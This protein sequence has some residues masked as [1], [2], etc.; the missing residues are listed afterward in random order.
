MIY[1][2]T[3]FGKHEYEY[4]NKKFSIEIKSLNNK[5]TDIFLRLPSI[6]RDKE[7]EV[8]KAIMSKLSRGKIECYITCDVLAGDSPATIDQNVALSYVEQIRPILSKLDNQDITE[9]SLQAIFRLPEVIKNKDISLENDEW[10]S[11]QEGLS[12]AL[13]KISEYRKDEG[14]ALAA[15]ISSNIRA[16]DKLRTRLQNHDTERVEKVRQKLTDMLKRL[17]IS[18]GYNEERLEQE[19]IFYIEKYDIN[20]ENIRLEQHCKY[21]LD[22]MNETPCGKKLGF[23]AQ[24]IGREINT[25]GSKANSQDITRLTVEM[26]DHLERIKEQVLNI[27]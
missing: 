19:L 11:F 5:N 18:D 23:I 17:N 12:S 7:M 26:K 16:I 3:G 25:I 1:S 27:L 15:D 20:E 9:K 14:A 21:F 6:I 2:M 10:S 8:R 24:E 22:T 4:Q 13:D